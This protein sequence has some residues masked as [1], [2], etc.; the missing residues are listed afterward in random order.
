MKGCYKKNSDELFSIFSGRK[1]RSKY[2]MQKLRVS[3]DTA[4]PSKKLLKKLLGEVL[5]PIHQRFEHK[6]VSGICNCLYLLIT[7]TTAV[8][9]LHDLSKFPFIFTFLGSFQSY[10][11]IQ[12]WKYDGFP[13][14][15]QTRK[16]QERTQ[17]MRL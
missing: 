3:T 13:K 10:R 17:I 12:A 6:C 11:K 5:S 7:N 14:V 1:T 9:R 2:N 16:S 4:I 15:R 8:R